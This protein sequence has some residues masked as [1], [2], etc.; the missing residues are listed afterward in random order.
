MFNTSVGGSGVY[1]SE[2]W[3]NSSGSVITNI[4]AVPAG[5][6]TVVVTDNLG[7]TGTAIAIVVNLTGP[8]ALI[9]G[10]TDATCFGLCDGNASVSV[11]GGT[12][13]YTYSWTPNPA[14]GQGTSTISGLCAGIYTVDVIDFNGCSNSTFVTISQPTAVS[15]S[16]TL[17]V[18]TSGAG[19]CDGQASVAASGGS[20]TYTYTWYNTCAATTINSSISGTNATGLCAGSYAVIATDGAGCP[21]T[22]CITVIEPNPIL[23]SIIGNDALCNGSCDGEATATVIGGIQPYTYEWY[24]SP[25][26]TSLN[27]FSLT[28]NNLCA[29]NYYIAVTDANGI[30]INSAIYTIG[31]P[32]NVTA[33]TSVISSYNGQDISCF[34]SCDGSA[35]VFPNGGTAPYSYLWNANANNQSTPIAINLCAGNYL[36]DVIDSNGC[37]FNTNIVLNSP[38]QVI[39]TIASLDASCNG[40]CDGS[41]TANTNGGLAPYSYLWNNSSFS[42][43][44]TINNLCAGLYNITITDNNGCVINDSISISEPIALVL[45]STITGSKL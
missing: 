34:G 40:I 22:L 30:T 2:L 29:G 25:L 16:Q 39:N 26:N 5:T 35:E 27:Q 20:G 12:T 37:I 11:S 10:F 19:V 36:V 33:T 38:T 24:S 28:A 8:T 13:P 9:D 7:C 1:I 45:S 18:N 17:S 3:T 4:N 6:Y 14:S 31:E 15:L 23:I 41:A 43:T 21:D 44:S 42:T 32:T